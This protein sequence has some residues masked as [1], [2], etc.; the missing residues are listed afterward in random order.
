MQ[1]RRKLP[2]KKIQDNFFWDLIQDK[3][4]SSSAS[5]YPLRLDKI[6]VQN[7]FVSE[8][9]LVFSWPQNLFP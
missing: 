8:Q 6:K 1:P 7:S 9:G 4:K 5:K 3:I 2:E